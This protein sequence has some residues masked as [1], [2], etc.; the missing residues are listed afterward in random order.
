M[1]FYRKLIFKLLPFTLGILITIL[2]Y[3]IITISYSFNEKKNILKYEKTLK[4]LGEQA[5]IYNDVPVACLLLYKDSIIGKGY[6]DVVKNNNPSGHAEI[7]AV[8]NCFEKIGYK[9]FLKLNRN[10]LYLITTYE[11]CVMCKGLIEEYNISNVVFAY[12]KKVQDKIIM[13][14]K[15]INYYKDLKQTTNPRLQYDLFKK[16]NFFDSIKYPY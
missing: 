15:D 3:Y 10:E 1:N 13:I 5:I 11:P 7:N 14:K 8:K 9:E 4:K 2:T 16:H 12:P 6:N